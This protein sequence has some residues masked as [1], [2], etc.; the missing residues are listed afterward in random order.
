MKQNFC[1]IDLETGGLDSNKDAVLEVAMVICN[2]SFKDLAVYESYVLPFQNLFVNEKALK[3]TNLK[4]EIINKEGVEEKKVVEA[5][6]D[7]LKSVNESGTGKGLPIIVGHNIQFD[8]NFLVKM[9]A[10]YNYD[11]NNFVS[12]VRIDTLGLAKIMWG[13]MLGYKEAKSYKLGDCCQREGVSVADSHRALN[14]VMATKGLLQF[15]VN[16]MQGGGEIKKNE[17]QKSRL[18]FQI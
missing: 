18:F 7:K 16:L 17:K 2:D 15:F 12:G 8:I 10:R 13:S 6:I 11:F 4:M 14:D 3:V 5:I 1:I 9:F